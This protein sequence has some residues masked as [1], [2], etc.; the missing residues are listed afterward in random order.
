MGSHENFDE[1]SEARRDSDLEGPSG[2]GEQRGDRDRESASPPVRTRP[3]S[4]GIRVLTAITAALLLFTLGLLAHP[5]LFRT[6]LLE[7]ELA[8]LHK[9]VAQLEASVEDLRVQIGKLRESFNAVQDRGSPPSQRASGPTPVAPDD[10]P[11]LGDADAPVLIVEFADFQCPYCRNFHEQTL[12]AL[13]RTYIETGKVRL[14][15][16]D[17]PLTQIHAHAAA[18]AQAAECAH[19]AG[20]F[21]AMHDQ[22]F[23]NQSRWSGSSDVEQL[24]ADYARDLGL[25]RESFAEC[26]SSG[27]YLDEI[28]NDLEAGLRAGVR[29]TPAFFING[30]KLEGAWPFSKFQEEIEAALSP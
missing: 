30:V 6:A 19:E 4:G 18:A 7:E 9:E 11:A 26:L 5:L 28:R 16:R 1:R 10:D 17:F 13:K 25:D 8:P 3:S 29:G 27:R 12:P 14:V 22:L 20:S 23:A 24:F 15:Y 21:W 2:G